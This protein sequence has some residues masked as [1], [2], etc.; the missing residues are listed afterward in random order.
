MGGLHYPLLNLKL[1]SLI[2][3]ERMKII[4][5]KKSTTMTKKYAPTDTYLSPLK[6]DTTSI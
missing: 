3:E 1:N 6:V 5:A 4:Y 2:P